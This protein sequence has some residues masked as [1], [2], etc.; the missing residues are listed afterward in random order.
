MHWFLNNNIKMFGIDS[1]ESAILNLKSKYQN[2]P[3]ENLQIANLAEIP[4]ANNFF[5]HIICSAV[6][7]FANDIDH[8]Q[9]MISEMVRV[10][11]TGG[12]LFIRM[13]SDIG[14][15]DKVK[16]LS[17]GNY[18]IPDG[19]MRFLLTRELL[20]ACLLKNNLDFIE[21]L[22]TVNVEDVRCMSTLV[23]KKL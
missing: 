22:K 8:F 18:K 3:Q 13:T 19:S 21:P 11:K 7:H 9:K 15:E 12:S 5:D 23:L 4:F 17:N 16:L 2:L 6:L 20:A 1:S 14:I 10:L